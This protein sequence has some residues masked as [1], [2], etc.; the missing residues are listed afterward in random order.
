MPVASRGAW[1]LAQ[2]LA[3][4][5]AAALA[6]PPQDADGQRLAGD[7]VELAW[8]VAGAG[9]VPL[10]DPFSL[11]VLLC[12][13]EATLRAVD[14]TMPAHRHGMNYRPSLRALGGGRWQVDGLLW[15]MA[16]T[17]ALR[18]DVQHGGSTQVLLQDVELP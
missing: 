6:C 1:A 18:M 10:A 14:A 17:W 3:L 16:G 12:P 4:V 5:P 11:Q 13:P 15:H 9:A 2:V 7:G 8:R